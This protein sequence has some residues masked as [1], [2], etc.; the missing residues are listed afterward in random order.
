MYYLSHENKFISCVI[1][2]TPVTNLLF[3]FI[4]QSLL[5]YSDNFAKLNMRFSYD[6][7]FLLC[8]FVAF[9][10]ISQKSVSM[11]NIDSCTL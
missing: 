2:L 11:S 7:V 4:D 1:Y 9:E 5:K 8:K 6:F 10:L 3:L